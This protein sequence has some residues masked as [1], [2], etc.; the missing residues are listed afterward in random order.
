MKTKLIALALFLASAVQAQGLNSYP[1]VVRV[2]SAMFAHT[3][4]LQ[5]GETVYVSDEICRSAE[6]GQS[7]PA[8]LEEKRI[9]LLVG[10]RVCRYRIVGTV[11]ERH[12]LVRRGCLESGQGNWTACGEK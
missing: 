1:L 5:V 4:E 2:N 10:G 12:T 11:E 7:Y 9:N 8:Q 6:V 3:T